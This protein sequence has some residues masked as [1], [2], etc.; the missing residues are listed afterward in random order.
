MTFLLDS[1]STECPSCYHWLAAGRSPLPT[2]VHPGINK[3]PLPLHDASLYCY[4]L[5]SFII[6]GRVLS[7]LS[8]MLIVS[9]SGCL[10]SFLVFWKV[11]TDNFSWNMIFFNNSEV[12]TNKITPMDKMCF[13]NIAYCMRLAFLGGF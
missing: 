4:S 9:V 7:V 11:E 12:L 13:I 6:T 8:G 10:E 5:Q 3:V 1:S 2:P